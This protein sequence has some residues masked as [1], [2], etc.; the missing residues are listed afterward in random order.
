MTRRILLVDDEKEFAEYTARR[1]RVRGAEVQVVHDGQGA[2]DTLGQEE[3][4]VIILDMLM[5][6]LSGLE[7]LEQI[8]CLHPKSRVIV[9]SGHA[10]EDAANNVLRLGAHAYLRKPCEFSELLAAIERLL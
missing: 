8:H 2:L 4:G 5:P 3:F 6:G 1:L 9:L 7:V 10:N